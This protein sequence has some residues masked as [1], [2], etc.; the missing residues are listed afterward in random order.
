VATIQL[1]STPV[2]TCDHLFTVADPEGKFGHGPHPVWLHSLWSPSDE[3]M[4]VH[5]ILGNVGY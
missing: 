5:E 1:N 2:I 4:N 3:E